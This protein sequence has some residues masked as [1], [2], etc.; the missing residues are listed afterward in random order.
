MIHR[1]GIKMI[2]KAIFLPVEYTRWRRNDNS[3]TFKKELKISRE[4]HVGARY[5]FAIR[6]SSLPQRPA[7]RF[8]THCRHFL[9]QPLF[10][11]FLPPSLLL[12][13]MHPSSSSSEGTRD[14]VRARARHDRRTNSVTDTSSSSRS[15]FLFLS[16]LSAFEFW[17]VLFEYAILILHLYYIIIVIEEDMYFER[18]C[19]RI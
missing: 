1:C 14:R 9:L 3:K 13:P 7:W 2:K 15:Y 4:S 11:F 18:D 8:G 12:S 16:F 5:A 17:G 6:A 19:R 10:L